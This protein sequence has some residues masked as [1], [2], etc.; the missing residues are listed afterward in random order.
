MKY[1]QYYN[2]NIEPTYETKFIYKGCTWTF[3]MS[4][5]YSRECML[6]KTPQIEHINIIDFKLS[7]NYIWGDDKIDFIYTESH[8]FRGE[9]NEYERKI[10]LES[11]IEY[12]KLHNEYIQNN[13]NE[14][15]YGYIIPLPEE[16]GK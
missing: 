15:V 13:H 10:S 14:D 8:T 9:Y 11:L 6:Y 1:T 16:L 12:I 3:P 5:T 7:N 4:L 2:S